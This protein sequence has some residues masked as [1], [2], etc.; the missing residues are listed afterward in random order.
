[1]KQIYNFERQAP[2]I[3]NENMLRAEN[4]RRKTRR[5]TALLAVSSL[6]ILLSV[7]L[8][9]IQLYEVVPILSVAC[10]S[11]I[12]IAVTGSSVIAIV[13]AQKRRSFEK[14]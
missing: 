11:Y 6:L 14:C 10:V 1:M 8:L 2:P 7:L 3:L 4:E 12:C 13:Y 9:A 5:I